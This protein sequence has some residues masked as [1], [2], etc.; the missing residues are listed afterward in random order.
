M[1]M[2]LH[3]RSLL[4]VTVLVGVVGNVHG[5]IVSLDDPPRP[6]VPKKPATAQEIQQ[7]E[8]LKK[9]VFGLLC[10]REIRLD[11]ALKAFEEAA[12]L[13]PEAPAVIKAQVPILIATNRLEDALGACKKV[14]A[15]D[16]AD[17]ASWYV[18]GKLLKTMVKYPEAIAALEQGL[19][20]A[21]IADHPEAAQQLYFELGS[22]RENAGQFGAAADAFNKAAAILER[23]T[24]IMDKGPFPRAAID[25]RA[26]ETYE[27]ISQLYRKAK[28][29]QPAIAAL[30]KAQEHAPDRAGRL[31]FHL[32]SLCIEQ[33]DLPQALVHVDAYL[34]TQPLGLEAYEMKIDLLQKLKQTDGLVAWLEDAAR[35]DANNAGLQLLLA[36]E[37][38][39]GRQTTKAEQLFKKLAEESPSAELYRGLF[40]LHQ[41]QGAAGMARVLAMLDNVIAKVSQEDRAGPSST[42]THARAMVAAVRDD[43]ELAKELVQTAFTQSPRKDDDLKFDTVYFL[44]VIADGQHKTAEAERFYRKCLLN[45]TPEKEALVYDGL[46]RALAKARKHE[47]IVEVCQDGL[48]KAKATNDLLFFKEL[49]RALANLQRYD[50][51]LKT[52]DRGVSQA[53]ED[54]KLIFKILRVSI[55]T[56]AE[57]FADAET[58]CTSLLK[59]YDRPAAHIELRYLLSN[60]YSAAKQ[61]AKAEEQLQM[62]LKIDPDNATVNNDLGYLW[63][64]QGRKLEVAEDMIRKALEVDRSQR[65]KSPNYNADQ[66][67][68]NAAYVDSL[69]WV[70]FRRGHIEEARKELERA[71]SLGDGDD[72]VIYEHLGDVYHRL[73]MRAEASRAWQRALELY[74]HGTRRKDDERVRDIQRKINQVK[75]EIGGR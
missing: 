27:K 65:R 8:S 61:Q 18:Q 3:V 40:Q 32:A 16:P 1:S 13:D 37:Y 63:A 9:Y 59:T 15:L 72:P 7:R 43:A 44:A 36:K 12:R 70:L 6:Y 46:L 2:C 4:V 14:V 53:K 21:R 51:A 38:A 60:V 57:R 25:A 52:A 24:L 64:D 68:D 54:A 55:L 74:N 47:S 22:M 23:P 34:R 41:Q 35:R 58:E 20:S 48:K 30:R 62:I 28:Q 71:T 11:D 5:Q 26:A 73:R 50:E 10:E 31:S 75:E 29:Y 19:K 56:L 66:D 45:T 39:R 17:Y 33:G 42:L 69:G 49:A 67:K